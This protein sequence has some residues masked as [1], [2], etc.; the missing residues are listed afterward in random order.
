LE[1]WLD[2]RREASPL[3]L[4]GRRNLRSNNSWMHN[5]PSLAK[6]PHRARLLMHPIDAR[7]RQ[8]PASARVRVTSRVGSIEAE[9]EISDTMM[10]GVVSL[11]HGLGHA[12]ARETLHV[13]GALP[14]PNANALTDDANIEP[15]V[16][17]SILNGVPVSVA[18]VERRVARDPRS[19]PG[20][21]LAQKP[22]AIS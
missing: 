2:R 5:L 15:L 1:A 20:A 13:A 14:G 8:L 16:G 7:D 19:Q 9:V 10:P 11:P 6:G 22:P 3:Q 18:P 21:S 4:I 17:T 12:A